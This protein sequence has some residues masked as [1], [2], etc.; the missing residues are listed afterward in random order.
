[1]GQHIAHSILWALSIY[2][3]RAQT[4][5]REGTSVVGHPASMA[6]TPEQTH[7]RERGRESLDTYNDILQDLR[8]R[9]A[10]C[11]VV[12]GHVSKES[13][14]YIHFSITGLECVVA[15]SA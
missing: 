6:S 10:T 2:S 14:K 1:M 9:H 3:T 15:V 11:L 5:Q 4:L 12:C 13:F 7:E 8:I